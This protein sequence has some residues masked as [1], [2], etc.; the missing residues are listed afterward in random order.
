MS[1]FTVAPIGTCRLHTPL[2]RGKLR[3]GYRLQLAQNYGFTHTSAEALQQLRFM[4]GEIAF[5]DDVARLIRRAAPPRAQGSRSHDLA[6][7]YLVEISSAKVLTCRDHY[8][9]LNYVYRYFADFFADK[10]RTRWFWTLASDSRA[11]ELQQRLAADPAYNRLDAVD[12]ALLADL[13]QSETTPDSLER[14]VTGLIDRLGRERL[15]L[16]THVNAQLS[17]GSVIATRSRLIDEVAAC[18]ARLGVRC[19]DPTPLMQLLGQAQAM[20]RFGLD[21]TH[22]TD[23][24]SDRLCAALHAAFMPSDAVTVV[25][26]EPSHVATEA[27]RQSAAD[28]EAAWVGGDFRAAS[29]GVRAALAADPAAPELRHLLGR[30]QFE[31]G[32]YRGAETNLEQ[33]RDA[34]GSD[35]GVD[36]ML[37]LTSFELGKFDRALRFGEALLGDEVETPEILRVCAASATAT[38]QTETAI[39]HWKRLFWLDSSEDAASAVLTLLARADRASA[40][41]WAENILAV[42]PSHAGSLAH[43]WHDGIAR[44]DRRYLL[45]TMSR[46]AMLPADRLMALAAAAAQA[47]PLASAQLLATR[48]HGGNADAGAW[49]TTNVALWAGR[50]AAAVAAGAA[51]DAVEPIQAALLL[52]P[53]NKDLVRAARML[54]RTLRIEARAAIRA[55]DHARVIAIGEEALATGLDF[56]E[57]DVFLGKAYL[58]VGRVDEALRHLR[59]AAVADASPAAWLQLARRALRFNRYAEAIEACLEAQRGPDS[60]IVAAASKLLAGLN[61]RAL[62]AV[63]SLAAA[64]AFEAAWGLT[65]AMLECSTDD[66][67]IV[68]ERSAVLRAMRDAIAALDKADGGQRLALA[69]RVLALDPADAYALRTAAVETMRAHEFEASLGH[70]SDL[71]KGGSDL[72]R[73]DINIEKCRLWITRQYRGSGRAAL[74]VAA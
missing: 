38:G 70:W 72:A 11:A 53:D 55:R 43:L 21:L 62:R 46:Y 33:A 7:L 34:L 61:S 8:V 15:V 40:S 23:T 56:A 17:D 10:E 2:R 30:M 59:L 74:A 64:G 48:V 18:A 68:R 1:D 66:V 13:R 12:R 4:L 31:L 37:M 73:L 28:L 51:L 3:Y 41:A 36:H 32:D 45:A 52:Q 44:G 39:N 54:A 69:R 6:D 14:D 9:Q 50:G 5:P 63:R 42:L 22:F 29:R 35:G 65:A 26:P 16:V 19:F 20:E 58:E 27:L 67:G 49:A 71:K 25:D 24:F 57:I 47:V 60:D